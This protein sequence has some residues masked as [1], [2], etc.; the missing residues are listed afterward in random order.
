MIL[1]DASKLALDW[2]PYDI[3]TNCETESYVFNGYL[4]TREDFFCLFFKQT[5][6]R[7]KLQPL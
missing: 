1:S 5:I 3:T 7:Q 6:V 2:E 4:L